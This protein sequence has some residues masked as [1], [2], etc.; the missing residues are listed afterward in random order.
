MRTPAAAGPTVS[1]AVWTALSVAFADRRRSSG[2]SVGLSD[3]MAG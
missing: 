2:T 3:D 1:E